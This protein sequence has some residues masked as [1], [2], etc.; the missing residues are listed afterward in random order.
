MC[1]WRWQSLTLF[2]TVTANEQPAGGPRGIN[3]KIQPR[4]KSVERTVVISPKKDQ[5]SLRFE[6]NSICER[7]IRH[8]VR[9][10]SLAG[11]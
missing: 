1:C 3:V 8:F 4:P 5:P 6:D 2:V 10:H 11:L 9:S 7:F